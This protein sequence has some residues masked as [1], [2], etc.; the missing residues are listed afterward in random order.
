MK[1]YIIV[2]SDGNQ[3][4]DPYKYKGLAIWE[5]EARHMAGYHI[6]PIE[7]DTGNEIPMDNERT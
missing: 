6:E 1:H 2:D 4:G 3:V 7:E 5:A